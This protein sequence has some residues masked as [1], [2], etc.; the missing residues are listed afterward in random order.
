MDFVFSFLGKGFNTVNFRSK[1]LQS[2]LGLNKFSF[3]EKAIIVKTNKNKKI[4]ANTSMIFFI[5]SLF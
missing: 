4:I 3:L 5:K 1:I 2:S